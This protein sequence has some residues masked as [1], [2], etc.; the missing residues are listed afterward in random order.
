MDNTCNHQWKNY[1]VYIQCELC[2]EIRMSNRMRSIGGLNLKENPLNNIT[3]D[4]SMRLKSLKL[5]DKD[6]V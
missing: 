5:N 1:S 3:E 2:G 6:D 4:V